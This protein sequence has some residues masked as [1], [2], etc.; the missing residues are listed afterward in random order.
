MAIYVS[1]AT[2]LHLQFGRTGIVNFGVVGF[3]GLGLYGIGVFYIQFGIPFFIAMIMATVLT[4]LLAYILGWI[5]LRLG[6]QEVLVATLAFATIIADLVTVQKGLTRGVKGLGSL[7]FP[8]DAGLSSQLV[9][10]II[11]VIIMVLL[12]AY[13]AK[14]EKTPYGRLL[15]SIQDNELLSQSLGKRTFKEK[16]WFFT[17][18]SAVMGFLGTMYASNAHFLMPSMLEPGLTFTIWIALII[19]GRTKVFGGLVGVLVTVGIFDFLIETYVPIPTARAQLLPIAK[20][21]VYGLTLLLVLMYKPAGLLGGQR[22]KLSK[23]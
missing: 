8:I 20:M 12:I 19:G 5:I 18:T 21:M 17:I 6:P 22:K 10:F 11:V 14:I 4:G 23:Q 1:L 9:F 16:L 13:A 2:L 3:F 15:M 7:P